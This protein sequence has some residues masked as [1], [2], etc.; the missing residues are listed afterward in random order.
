MNA[1]AP[2]FEAAEIMSNKWGIEARQQ[3]KLP[4]RLAA[5]VEVE[6]TVGQRIEISNRNQF[7]QHIYLPIIDCVIDEFRLWYSRICA[8]KGR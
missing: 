4:K 5:S 3:R 1:V 6:Q 8:E 7:R 2:L